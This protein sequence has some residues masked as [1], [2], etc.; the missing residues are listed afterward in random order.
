MSESIPEYIERFEKMLQTG[1]TVFFDRE[2]FYD[3]AHYY[4]DVFDTDK[5][6]KA[7]DYGMAMYPNDAEMKAHKALYL[8]WL[9]QNEKALEIIISLP[10][11]SEYVK[12]VKADILASCGH[13]DEALSIIDQI[14]NAIDSSQLDCLE[15]YDIL[16]AH[17]YYNEALIMLQTIKNRFGESHDIRCDEVHINEMLENYSVCLTGLNA[18]LDEDPY[19]AGMWCHLAQV[20]NKMGNIEQ[21]LESCNFALAINPQDT[22]ALQIKALIHYENK[23]VEL[24]RDI[25]IEI[26]E[27]RPNDYTVLLGLG[28]CYWILKDYAN[29]LKYLKE[30]I[31][32][33]TEIVEANYM[34][35]HCA[36]QLG[37]YQTGIDVLRPVFEA[38][39]ED[40][41]M[42]ILH[43]D[44]LLG[45][46]TSITVIYPY[47]VDIIESSEGQMNQ[48]WMVKAYCDEYMKDYAKAISS[49]LKAYENNYLPELAIYR[50][51]LIIDDLS[52]RKTIH[53]SV[54]F[55]D[56]LIEQIPD[57]EEGRYELL[58]IPEVFDIPQWVIDELI[59]TS[60]KYLLNYESHD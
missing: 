36:F 12:K 50:L 32:I 17:E 3:I 26:N 15:A 11:E 55:I 16:I 6:I 44:L 18:L 42:K 41:R 46:N 56:Y 29:S 48:Y 39:R 20:Y 28:D 54:N 30:A 33:E 25:F 4:E 21:A 19:D 37:E 27:L 8:L 47:L 38:K 5:A 31:E 59:E 10:A 58:V 60:K 23:N 45:L 2:E 22:I 9:N 1:E 57:F 49:Y 52:I 13:K 24:A 40:L 51:L 53:L 14:I 7:V 34:A 43:M 35:A